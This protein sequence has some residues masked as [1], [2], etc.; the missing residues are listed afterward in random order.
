VHHLQQRYTGLQAQLLRLLPGRHPGDH[1]IRVG[2]VEERAWWL[3][4]HRGRAAALGHDQ[5]LV[6]QHRKSPPNGHPAHPVQPADAVLR[7]QCTTRRIPPCADLVPQEFGQ[8]QV[9]GSR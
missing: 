4:P 5:A 2:Q 6:P 8:L 1:P 3:Q 9:H 7:R